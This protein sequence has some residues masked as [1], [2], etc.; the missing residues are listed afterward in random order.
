MRVLT[1][2]YWNPLAGAGEFPE[3]PNQKTFFTGRYK[4][5]EQPRSG[6]SIA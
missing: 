4:F 3:K 6:K 5:E 1:K 2:G